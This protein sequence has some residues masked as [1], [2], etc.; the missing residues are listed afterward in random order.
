M[1]QVIKWYEPLIINYNGTPQLQIKI[2]TEC[3]L[4]RNV[5]TFQEHPAYSSELWG[6]NSRYEEKAEWCAGNV[7]KNRV[8]QNCGVH[9]TPPEK[10]KDVIARE[11]GEE[12]VLRAE[13]ILREL[14]VQSTTKRGRAPSP[15]DSVYTYPGW[16]GMSQGEYSL[17]KTDLR[18][19]DW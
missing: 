11:V 10:E 1:P 12:L 7:C 4:C 5:A 8:C 15:D 13:R 17:G 3:P 18:I 2:C 19:G 9:F 14:G 6:G 16:T